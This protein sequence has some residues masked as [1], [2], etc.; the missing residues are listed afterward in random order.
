MRI[1]PGQWMW[2]ALVSGLLGCQ[3]ASVPEPQG[4]QKPERP[5]SLA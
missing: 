4:L 1:G 2:G 3:Q 5:L